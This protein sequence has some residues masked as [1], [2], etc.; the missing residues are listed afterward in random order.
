MSKRG[1][2]FLGIGTAATVFA[3][4]ALLV[5]IFERKQEAKTT[6]VKVVDVAER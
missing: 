3:V 6:Y 2:L 1:Y 4:L 5:S